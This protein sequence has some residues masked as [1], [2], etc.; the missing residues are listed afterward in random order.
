MKKIIICLLAC[1]SLNACVKAGDFDLLPVR[2]KIFNKYRGYGI[3]FY[4]NKEVLLSEGKKYTKKGF[5]YEKVEKM[6]DE[7]LFFVLY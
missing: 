2:T 7:S 4:D 6:L 1:L 3:D 5:F